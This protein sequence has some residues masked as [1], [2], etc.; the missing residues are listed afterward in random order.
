MHLSNK[1]I[2]LYD[3]DNVVNEC[4]EEL[5]LDVEFVYVILFS[6]DGWDEIRNGDNVSFY[7]G[8][9][10]ELISDIKNY[11]DDAFY[12]P[13]VE[14]LEESNKCWN[15]L[16]IEDKI[17]IVYSIKQWMRKNLLLDENLDPKIMI[18]FN[19]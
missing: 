4:I 19:W 3:V 5:K 6:L 18:T 14:Y 16:L 1:T 7:E 12:S 8:S 2:L 15:N 11:E 9:F 17:V 13:L 10:D